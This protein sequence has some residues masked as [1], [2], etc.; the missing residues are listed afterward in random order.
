MKL[1]K[2]SQTTNH[3]YD[4]YDSAVVAAETEI[5]AKRTH[6]DGSDGGDT[7]DSQASEFGWR[8][9]NG[10]FGETYNW[11]RKAEDVTAELIG[12]AVPGTKAGVI[13]ASFNAG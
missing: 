12:E 7:W 5:E 4:T 9:S 11:C 10:V 6:P 13:V 2:I 3:G 8:S 1:W